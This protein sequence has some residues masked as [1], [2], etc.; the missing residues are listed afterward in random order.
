MRRRSREPA[1]A[2]MTG[3]DTDAAASRATWFD[4]RR[5]RDLGS[6]AASREPQSRNDSRAPAFGNGA[7]ERSGM[8]IGTAGVERR[9]LGLE[10]VVAERVSA[11]RLEALHRRHR[12]DDG[13]DAPF[14]SPAHELA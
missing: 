2:D 1:F 10:R 5:V 8:T 9:A 14:L 6:S 4:R 7:P 12:G 3:A 11:R 13:D